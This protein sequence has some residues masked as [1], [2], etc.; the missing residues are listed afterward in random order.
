MAA[1]IRSLR[2]TV[3]ALLLL[4]APYAAMPAW[5][6]ADGWVHGLALQGQPN[7]PSDFRHFDYVNPDAPKAGL[8][9]LGRQ[10]SF[11]NFNLVVAGVKGQIE[12]GCRARL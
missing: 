1:S 4:G 11:D 6:G 10:G 3:V 9:R 5:A 2:R 7:Y 8:V 12:G